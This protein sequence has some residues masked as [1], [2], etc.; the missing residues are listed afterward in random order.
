LPK[1]V[2]GD[3]VS[4]MMINL[5]KQTYR[6][7]I[8]SFSIWA[9]LVAVLI[10]VIVPGAQ[11]AL[12]ENRTRA[13]HTFFAGCT[14]VEPD[15]NA[16]LHW[17]YSNF[18]DDVAS[19]SLVAPKSPFRFNSKKNRWHGPDGK[20]IKKPTAGQLRD[21]AKSQGWKN[22]KTTPAG[23]ESWTDS[24][25]QIRMKIKPPSTQQGL[26]PGSKV[27]RVTIWNE[28]GQRVDGFGRVVTKKSPT[29]HAPIEW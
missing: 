10:A 17:V 23:F 25:G 14:G 21:Y 7:Q 8:R 15:L 24:A 19:G 28:T 5:G 26:G 22:T 6:P 27:P 12:S 18:Y 29:A 13:Y 4:A 9:L 20:F 11:A 1:T 2:N 16:E 3:T